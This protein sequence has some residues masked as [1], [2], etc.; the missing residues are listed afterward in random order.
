[1]IFELNVVGS[2]NSSD[3][4]SSCPVDRVECNS[5]SSDVNVL[6]LVLISECRE[7]TFISDGI[8]IESL[9]SMD[10]LGQFVVSLNSELRTRIAFVVLL[11]LHVSDSTVCKRISHYGIS[12]IVWVRCNVHS[13][14]ET[15]ITLVVYWRREDFQFE[16][17]HSHLHISK[18]P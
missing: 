17:L 14:I 10:S 2:N 13:T 5:S 16:A 6:G 11:L 15:I 8:G 3:G 9:H 1:M 18:C 12:T 7:P 4:I